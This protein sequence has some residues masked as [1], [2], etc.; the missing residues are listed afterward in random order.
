MS[1]F[2]VPVASRKIAS[3]LSP[4]REYPVTVHTTGLALN[5][6][7]HTSSAHS[8]VRSSAGVKDTSTSTQPCAGTVPWLGLTEKQG[9]ERSS[10][11]WNSNSIGTWGAERVS[12]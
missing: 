1:G 4:G 6:A 3:L 12:G 5:S 11:I 8:S 9:F 2:A 10:L 7:T